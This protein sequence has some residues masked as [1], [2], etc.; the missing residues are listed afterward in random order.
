MDDPAS[1][2]N[3]ELTTRCTVN[4]HPTTNRSAVNMK[5]DR[6]KNFCLIG[7]SLDYTH[8]VMLAVI[9]ME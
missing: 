1:Y 5:T 2:T 3:W 9:K 6:M 4:Y 8:N 7:I